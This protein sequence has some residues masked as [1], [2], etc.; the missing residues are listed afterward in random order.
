MC[1]INNI[2]SSKKLE[3]SNGATTIKCVIKHYLE[4]FTSKLLP[5][6][7]ISLIFAKNKKTTNL[8]N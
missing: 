5:F 3:K 2:Q 4:N 6:A 7:K 1:T 8:K